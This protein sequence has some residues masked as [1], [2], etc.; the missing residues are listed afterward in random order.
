MDVV[1]VFEYTPI[2]MNTSIKPNRC[3]MNTEQVQK[4][5][6]YLSVEHNM[7]HNKKEHNLYRNEM[8]LK[9]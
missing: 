9:W 2:K 1:V 7:N 6:R 4:K 8:I 3:K 5:K